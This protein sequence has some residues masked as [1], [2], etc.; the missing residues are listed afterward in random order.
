MALIPLA[1][2]EVRKPSQTRWMPSRRLPYWALQLCVGGHFAS[3]HYT[4]LALSSHVR[5]MLL[6]LISRR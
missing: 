1:E 2:V 5:F 6:T 3:P 4:R